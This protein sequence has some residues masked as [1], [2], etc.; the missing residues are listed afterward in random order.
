MKK[1]QK[2][3][4]YSQTKMIQNNFTLDKRPFKVAIFF[5]IAISLFNSCKKVETDL[6]VDVL[7]SEDQLNVQTDTFTLTTNT[8]LEDSLRS[9]ELSNNMLGSY[10]DPT[11][12]EVDASIYTQIRLSSFNPNFGAFPVID[13]V[14]L[15][16]KIAG[17]YGNVSPL[18]FDVLQL[19]EKLSK[20][21]AYYTNSSKATGVSLI[22]SGFET[23]TP[24]LTAEP[25]ID[26]NT[27]DPQIRIR[28]NESFGDDIVTASVNGDLASDTSFANYFKGILIQASNPSG[29]DQ[30]GVYLLDLVHT[31]SKITIYYHNSADTL[32]YE[33]PINDNCARFTHI[34]H[35]YTGT[36]IEQ[37]IQTPSLG[38]TFFYV[39]AGAGV[40]SNIVLDNILDLRNQGNIIINKAELVLPV[41]HYSISPYTPP[42][43]LIAFGLNSDGEIYSMPDFI[44]PGTSVFGGNYDDSKKAYVFNIVRYV[45]DIVTGDLENNPIRI[46]STSSSVSV[47]RV[48]M[49]GKNSP[50]REKPYLKVYY[51]K[52]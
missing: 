39:Q 38:N 13:S 33:M 48:I 32:K 2:K 46:A 3:I 50:N 34:D 37:Q 35:D 17:H 15:S 18:T 4:P 10:H 6:G 11:F 23:F 20:D 24:S 47:N 52:Y 27:L 40:V 25:V 30:G 49:S 21:S 19:T 44:F 16:M 22:K 36:P 31:D 28:L 29:P 51:T 1:L 7:P 8:L 41:Q 12:G 5:L 45:Q 14:V 9:D 26:G 43:K 42:L